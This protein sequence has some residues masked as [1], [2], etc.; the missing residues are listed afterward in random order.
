MPTGNNATLQD[1]IDAQNA[2]IATQS[3][4]ISTLKTQTAT[5]LQNL[6]ALGNRVYGYNHTAVVRQNLE[7]VHNGIITANPALAN[8]SAVGFTALL[9]D[10]DVIPTQ[11]SRLFINGVEESGDY[12]FSGENSSDGTEF[13]KVWYFPLNGT[14]QL[15]DSVNLDIVDF[16][17]I[18]RNDL[19]S[20]FTVD[21]SYYKYAKYI[22]IA[23]IDISSW[24]VCG[25]KIKTHFLNSGNGNILQCEEYEDDGMTSVDTAQYQ[26]NPIA[27]NSTANVKKLI[28]PNLT[29]FKLDT[30]GWGFFTKNF[31]NAEIVV[32]SLEICNGT[33]ATVDTASSFVNINKIVMPESV[34]TLGRGSFYNIRNLHLNCKNA[35]ITGSWYG[36]TAPQ[37]FSVCS[38]WGATIN[39]SVA[40]ANWSKEDFIE[41]FTNRLRDMEDVAKELKIP[42]A[43]YDELT[44]EEFEIAENKG[45][46]IG[47]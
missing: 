18:K 2:F 46:T 44:D 38:D 17:I 15:S 43:I 13:V 21:V 34:T 4:E 9:N 31:I 30:N 42:S 36:G 32:P 12:T 16:K 10:G 28:F 47:A 27:A 11:G 7:T 5:A 22:D 25:R 3:Q 26:K 8:S 29:E 39:I 37:N 19:T 33:T 6:A 20:G 14:L 1:V 41:L 24:S 23:G 40:A 35:S 45:W